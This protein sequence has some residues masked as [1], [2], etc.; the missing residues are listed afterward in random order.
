M[1]VP[2]IW[3]RIRLDLTK[4]RI[5]GIRFFKKPDM[6]PDPDL[7]FGIKFIENRQINSLFVLIK[8]KIRAL[9]DIRIRPD[10]DEKPDIRL[11]GIRVFKKPD[12]RNPASQNPAGSRS[13]FWYKFHRK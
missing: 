12:I 10:F 4:N 3:I 9:P 1:A 7:D 2:D 6:G 13:G 8:S 11:S 5:S